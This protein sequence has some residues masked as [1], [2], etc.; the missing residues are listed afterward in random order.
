M[1][2]ILIVPSQF[3]TDIHKRE[4]IRLKNSLLQLKSLNFKKSLESFKSHM[5]C[6]ELYNYSDIP[7]LN[8]MKNTYILGNYY[9]EYTIKKI[10]ELT[11]YPSIHNNAEGNHINLKEALS[12]IHIYDAIIIGIRSGKVGNIIRKEGIKRNIPIIMIDYFDHKEIYSN[13]S[14]ENL[15][16]GL[17]PNYD[18]NIYFKH[19]LPIGL[20]KKNIYPLA[21]MP[22][23]PNNYPKINSDWSN[24]NINIFYRGRNS[25]N[26]R[27]DR[28]QITEII[29]NNIPNSIIEKINLNDNFT[30]N[31]YAFNLAK[32]KIAISP[33]GKVWD[34]T[35]HT[36]V[37]IFNC[38]PLIPEPDCEVVNDCI[39][40]GV[41][42]ITYNPLNVINNN[43]L[44]D[45]INF[46]LSNDS[47][48]EEIGKN[49]NKEV[50]SYHTINSRSKY[51]LDKINYL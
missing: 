47:K 32:S 9:R 40:D 16:R 1:K 13:S 19:D 39:K 17:K 33:S 45:K 34:S 14:Y 20:G 38:A 10:P 3:I 43:N 11:R 48:L 12:L 50:N 46:Y 44:I 8:G 41:N 36:E 24:K 7:I 21:P 26:P 5:L 18:F 22:C 27:A 29:N 28:I 23:N 35:R 51:I 42:A 37:S 49:W 2:N 4:I 31:D 15:F 30:L 6:T 25:H